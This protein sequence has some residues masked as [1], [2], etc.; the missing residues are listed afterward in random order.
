MWLSGGA[1]AQLPA[2]ATA[3]SMIWTVETVPANSNDWTEMGFVIAADGQP[4]MTFQDS[5]DAPSH[6]L[7]YAYRG[8]GYWHTET[9]RSGLYVG[10][11]SDVAVKPGGSIAIAYTANDSVHY[12]VPDRLG[13]EVDTVEAA[14]KHWYQDVGLGFAA[15]GTPQVG[16][17]DWD[18]DSVRYARYN[19]LEEKWEIETVASGSNAHFHVDAGGIPHFVYSSD[20]NVIHAARYSPG[21]SSETLGSG[22]SYSVAWKGSEPCLAYVYAGSNP[23]GL[24]YRCGAGGT[25]TLVDAQGRYPVLA[26]SPSAAPHI[27]YQVNWQPTYAVLHG[28]AWLKETVAQDLGNVNNARMF[29]DA[30]NRA[31]LGYKAGSQPQYARSDGSIVP[32]AAFTLSPD[33]VAFTAHFCHFQPANVLVTRRGEPTSKETTFDVALQIHGKQDVDWIVKAPSWVSVQP[34]QG[35]GPATLTVGLKLQPDEVKLKFGTRNG[36]VTVQSPD[37]KISADLAIK[38]EIAPRRYLDRKDITLLTDYVRNGFQYVEVAPDKSSRPVG[39]V[40]LWSVTGAGPYDHST[41]VINETQ[42]I[43]MRETAVIDDRFDAPKTGKGKYIPTKVYEPRFT[44]TFDESR[45]PT[46]YLNGTLPSET[47]DS[48]RR[49]NCHG[50]ASVVIFYGSQPTLRLGKGASA[51]IAPGAIQVN[52]GKAWYH[53]AAPMTVSTPP[54]SFTVHSECMVDVRSDGRAEFYLFEGSATFQGAHGS[55][56]LEPNEKVEVTADGQPG[57]VTAFDPSTIDPWWEWVDLG[58]SGET[59]LPTVLRR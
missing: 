56:E 23:A 27:L 47:S 51:T 7:V 50:F 9:V 49:W 57:L 18:T 4:H 20:G 17:W 42:Q 21:W 46:A 11:S 30:S 37:G 13:W 2:D 48:M 15:D 39:S 58:E 19:E 33:R 16:Y 5:T 54:G 44:G 35:K 40:I 10:E 6:K 45:V 28:G 55:A 12:A 38:A 26:I 24:Y 14:S 22:I 31:R 41:V 32:P 34:A 59:Y 43:G 8:D 52:R 53:G 29:V 25:E 3:S 36:T 1:A